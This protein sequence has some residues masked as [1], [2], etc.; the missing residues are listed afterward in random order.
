MHY[1]WPC[2]LFSICALGWAAGCAHTTDPNSSWGNNE[3]YEY[4]K[5]HSTS[6]DYPNVESA[7]LNE[8]L[9]TDSPRTISDRRDDKVQEIS[10]QEA[11][12]TALENNTIIRQAN[13]FGSPGNSI[14]TDRAASKFDPAIQESGV[15]FGTRGIEAALASFDTQFRSSMTWGR[16]EQAQNFDFG[17]T[18]A[19]IAVAETGN[20]QSSLQKNFAS[21]GLVQLNHNWNYRNT[22]GF[23]Q[24]GTVFPSS[25]AGLVSA[26]YTQPLLAGAGTEFT[27]VAGPIVQSFGGI[28]GVSQGVA[29]ARINNDLSLADFE[30]SIRNLLFDV[31]TLYWDLYMS[32]RRYDTAVA[33]FKSA[34][35]TWNESKIKLDIGTLKA[36]D[37]AQARDR[38]YE[39]RAQTE[40]ALSTL[41]DTELRLRRLLGM[42]VNDGS[43][44]RPA[45]DPS[46]AEVI[47]DWNAALAEALTGRVE[48]RRQKWNIKSLNLQL[49]AARSLI[50]PRLDFTA[51]YQV[52]GFGDRLLSSQ[53]DD[54]VDPGSNRPR[55]AYESIV[56]GNETG[57]NMGLT[58]SAPIGFRSE[59]A[60][61]RNYELRL[62]R[63]RENL[64]ATELEI[65]HELANAV[66]NLSRFY[67]IAQTNLNRRK[68]AQLRVEKLQYELDEGTITPDPLVRA[69]AS[70]A[71]AENAY[72]ESLVEYNKQIANV[73]YRKG[74]LLDSYNVYLAEGKWEPSAYREAERRAKA[75]TGAHPT[76]MQHAE[77]AEHA[78]PDFSGAAAVNP[79][80][81]QKSDV[82]GNHHEDT[83]VEHPASMKN[84][85]PAEAS[86]GANGMGFHSEPASPLNLSFE[87]PEPLN[88]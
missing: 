42:P 14:L 88:F 52:N 49:Q 34:Q 74:T 20:F 1:R 38:Y 12:Y 69:Q 46:A 10:L 17:G 24:F 32:Y 7:S 78:Y 75:R 87:D 68:A 8:S 57:W 4:F 62:A 71:T 83:A 40:S 70:L 41:Y 56:Q 43:I 22:P 80:I 2:L 30:S 59:K 25:Y 26:Q 27:R 73:H 85:L 5:Q 19:P 84:E 3:T 48:L 58:L 82:T 36:S 76:T 77:P 55:N 50:R 72:Y 60:Q 61:V 66:Q 15:L 86:E 53:K 64:A 79:G 47:P 33:S 35:Q 16:S 6:I 37:E 29:I 65:S 21:G 67:T 51:G 18:G 45:D 11:V 44:L 9:A 31:E 28:T 13:A 81:I 39:T 23:N 63:A 54:G